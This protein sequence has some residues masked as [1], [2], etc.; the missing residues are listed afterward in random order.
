MGIRCY[1]PNGHR[2]NLKAF[3]AGRVGICPDCQARFRIPIESEPKRELPVSA[4]PTNVPPSDPDEDS[5]VEA[6]AAAT[7]V[8]VTPAATHPTS[9]PAAWDEPVENAAVM[10]E[11]ESAPVAATVAGVGANPAPQPAT[12]ASQGSPAMEARPVVPESVAPPASAPPQPIDP[13][14][15][16]P[17]AVW[18]VRPPTGGQYGPAKGEI[19][20]RWVDEGRVTPDSLVWR[21]G[22]DDWCLAEGVFT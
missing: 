12:R 3:Q 15:Q 17:N 11:P 8:D 2:L 5:P 16:A 19:M 1:C 14:A 13:I 9:A 4:D 7:S 10:A 20:R 21:E 18:Y 22:W 6:P